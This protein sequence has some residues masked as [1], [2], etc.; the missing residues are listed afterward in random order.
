MSVSVI[1][2][3][4]LDCDISIAFLALGV[5]RRSWG[6]CPSTENAALVDGAEASVNR[7]LEQRF[8]AQQ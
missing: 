7:L 2:I 8:A 5:A 6:R 4:E 1:S 3:E